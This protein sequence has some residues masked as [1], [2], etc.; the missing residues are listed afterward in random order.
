MRPQ[1]VKQV[2]NYCSGKRFRRRG[3]VSDRQ[4]S[5]LP[6]APPPHCIITKTH[7]PGRSQISEGFDQPCEGQQEESLAGVPRSQNHA[8]GPLMQSE[9]RHLEQLT[10]TP[11][12]PDPDI[13]RHQ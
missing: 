12:T 3:D 9:M 4:G 6:L 7:R 13:L 8:D 11:G 2:L 10:P 1:G 5:Q